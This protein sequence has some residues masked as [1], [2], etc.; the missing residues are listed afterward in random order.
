MA[1]TLKIIDEIS[2]PVLDG[3]SSKEFLMLKCNDALKG[4]YVSVSHDEPL[5]WR[6]N[7]VVD[8]AVGRDQMII[9]SHP[10]PYP[11]D[12]DQII[13][14]IENKELVVTTNLERGFVS[15]DKNEGSG[16][17]QF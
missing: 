14:M 8:E 13:K 3:P 9:M 11:H 15:L 16:Q 17:E 10:V 2:L 12:A 4:R 1:C 6:P 5:P 7:I